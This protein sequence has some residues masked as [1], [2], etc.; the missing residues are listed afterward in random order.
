M[1]KQELSTK[2]IIFSSARINSD[3]E[4]YPT[5]PEIIHAV[6]CDLY[7]SID[8]Y[9]GDLVRGDRLDISILDCGCGDGRVLKAL[10]SG[11]KY[12]IEKSPTL[13]E[14]LDKDIFLV[15]TDFNCQQLLDKKVQ[16]IFSNPP[17]EFYSEWANKI[18]S[19]GAAQSIYLVLPKR[20]K[21]SKLI[22]DAIK[23]RSAE[24]SV[25]GD[26]DFH[27]ADRKVRKRGDKKVFVQLVKVRLG[28]KNSLRTGN[29]ETKYPFSSE[30]PFEIWFKKSFPLNIG[31]NSFSKHAF[32]NIKKQDMQ[33]NEE[34]HRDLINAKGM[35]FVLEEF[36][37]KDL[38]KLVKN[39]AAVCEIDPTI[40]Q[41]LGVTERN[42]RESIKLKIES[43][44]DTYWNRLFENLESITERL[45]EDR[46]KRIKDMLSKQT[47]VDFSSEN[48]HAI[49]MWVIKHS[50]EFIDDQLV[51]LVERMVG[52][53]NIRMYKSNLRT[54]LKEEWRYNRRPT[55]LERYKLEYR[56]VLS[57]KA[58]FTQ[59]GKL[60]VS[61]KEFLGDINIVA[62]SIGFRPVEYLEVLD[63]R[64]RAGDRHEFK[65]TDNVTKEEKILFDARGYENGNF[66]IRFNQEFICKL[67]VEF[68][69]L[70]GWL[71][72]WKEAADEMDITDEIAKK[73]F[74]CNEKI[75]IKS[76]TLLLN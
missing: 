18:I 66:H 44:K 3:F 64:W 58:G 41:E 65:F 8:G 62:S 37:V 34:N 75:A 53:K 29:Y 7:D 12:G 9:K 74:G 35:I 5:T 24:V 55:D 61:A 57:G 48:A 25:L 50:N 40:L 38:D 69:R 47:H 71:K 70:K 76:A 33:A 28:Y 2:S 32:E 31:N 16:V 56:V 22:N 19:E 43:L 60:T 20:W 67:N 6:A 63:G 42:I 30:D 13:I 52:D 68:G 26:F 45:C 1:T 10:S 23:L 39:Y 15:G 51:N 11:K 59:D 27:N 72:D 49:I 46:R 14:I 36:Y 21:L 73:I 54:F 17:F 4:F